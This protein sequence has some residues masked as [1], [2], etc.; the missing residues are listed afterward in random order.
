M[1]SISTRVRGA[2]RAIWR[3]ACSPVMR[4]MET[5]ITT[6][7]ASVSRA[8]CTASGPS[9][10]SATTSKSGCALRMRRTLDRRG[11]RVAAEPVG[12]QQH[13]GERLAELLVQLAGDPPALGLLCRH[14]AAGAVAALAL[15]AVEHVVERGLEF[16]H[17]A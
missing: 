12:L 8:A 14:R 11:R 10:A 16:L 2:S 6:S 9:A 7:S 1:E 13:P 15:Q 17:V 4:G 3:V 5:S